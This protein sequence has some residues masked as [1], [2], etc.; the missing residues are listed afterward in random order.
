MDNGSAVGFYDVTV[1]CEELYCLVGEAV[2]GLVRTLT[3]V[4]Y[5]V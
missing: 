1:V 4:P 3:A 5:N 2:D